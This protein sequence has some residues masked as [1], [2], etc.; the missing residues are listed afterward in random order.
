MTET[1][2]GELRP[3]PLPPQELRMGGSV[4]QDDAAFVESALRDV[5]YLRSRA[6]LTADSRMLDWGCGPGRLAVGVKHE[7]G[8][9]EDYH[10]VDVQRRLID[11]AN[12]NLAD[13]H[14][15]F[16][17]VDASNARYNPRGT[18]RQAI[19]AADES[20]DVFCA[21]SVFSHLLVDDAA[22]YLQIL[23][24]TLSRHGSAFIT[25]FVE[26]GAPPWEENPPDYIGGSWSGPLHCVRY[27]RR[28]FEALLESCGLE[29]VEFGYRDTGGQSSYLLGRK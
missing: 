3:I 25:A 24:R 26:N 27:N 28:L 20:V 19:P 29:V 23:A 22:T 16:S 21:Y 11:W 6:G 2:E 13:Q 14:T 10:G 1:K 12:A 5:R 17:A 18:N 7:F 15:R 4:F 8:H 9:I